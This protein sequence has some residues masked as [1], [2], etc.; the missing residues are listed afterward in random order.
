MRKF[1]NCFA[2][3]FEVLP[4]LIAVSPILWMGYIMSEAIAGK[5][6][7]GAFSFWYVMGLFGLLFTVGW[8][9]NYNLRRME[10]K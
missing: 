6:S 9:R 10:N 8:A 1:F 2:D 5:L 4:F 7:E 3:F